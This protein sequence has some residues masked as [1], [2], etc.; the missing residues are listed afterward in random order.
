MTI[1]DVDTNLEAYRLVYDPTRLL[2][3]LYSKYGDIE[4]DYYLLSANQIFYNLPSHLNITYKENKYLENNEEFL[5]RFYK[6]IETKDRIPKLADY[7]KNYHLFFCRPF[8][9]NNKFGKIIR[10]YED[11]KAEIF[12]KNNYADSEN[13]L[14]DKEKDTEDK[15]GSSTL[16]SLDNITDNKII[17]DRRTKK[18]IENIDKNE[19]SSITLTLDS[20][21]ANNYLNNT[22]CLVSKRSVGSFEKNIYALVN[23]HIKK[24]I[25]NKRKCQK[26]PKN[27]TTRE[28]REKYSSPLC[29]FSYLSKNSNFNTKKN[30]SKNQY[31]KQIKNKNSL[32]SLVLNKNRINK[33]HNKAI[34]I[35]KGKNFFSPKCPFNK[36]NIVT[37]FEEFNKNRPLSGNMGSH[38]KNKTTNNNITTNNNTNTIKNGNT[39]NYKNFSKLSESLDK[40]KNINNINSTT[41]S[42]I[43]PVTNNRNTK[44]TSKIARTKKNSNNFNNK[45]YNSSNLNYNNDNN[46][47]QNKKFYIT[48][49]TS[50][51]N[52]KQGKHSITNKNSNKNYKNHIH[53]IKNRTVDFNSLNQNMLKFNSNNNFE[54]KTSNQHSQSK[55]SKKNLGSK[56]TLVKGIAM[57]KEVITN[58]SMSS[59]I[60]KFQKNSISK[61]IN[62]QNGNN[63]LTTKEKKSKNNFTNLCSINNSNHYSTKIE[64]KSPDINSKPKKNRIVFSERKNKNYSKIK[65]NKRKQNKPRV[66]QTQPSAYSTDFNINFEKGNNTSNYNRDDPSIISPSSY[67]SEN[68]FHTNSKGNIFQLKQD[69]T[70]YRS[71]QNF[72]KM[73][74]DLIE[75]DKNS[76]QKKSNNKRSEK[77]NKINHNSSITKKSQ[78]F[79]DVVNMK[80]NYQV[81]RNRKRGNVSNINTQ[82][83]ELKFI[84]RNC[85]VTNTNNKD[86]TDIDGINTLKKNN[87]FYRS[88]N[89]NVDNTND[90]KIIHVAESLYKVNKFSHKKKRKPKIFLREK[91]K[92]VVKSKKKQKLSDGILNNGSIYNKKKYIAKKENSSKRNCKVIRKENFSSKSNNTITQRER[93]S[94][95]QMINVNRNLNLLGKFENKNKNEKQKNN[96]V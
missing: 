15:K 20:L 34:L 4:E 26:N 35:K 45:L 49:T 37:K 25:I 29:H 68:F 54:N 86:I 67:Y 42:N 33:A 50:I 64:Y 76:A 1:E 31:Y 73:K 92:C 2:S 30:N 74:I 61:S 10:D 89:N 79:Y 21:N 94:S 65:D 32:Y 40:N 53:H 24:K 81:S 82:S 3:L 62:Y 38:K 52:N 43:T 6:I 63:N 51:K 57:I 72:N 22:Q 23:Y 39:S 84:K 41:N 46:F 75:V 77:K 27:Q 88:Y 9:R 58:P 17:F 95:F 36:K 83:Q 11:N 85:Y 60:K 59:D 69:N 13:E 48:K 44:N 87:K 7:Y 70:I 71:N 91:A 14:E 12:Y 78:E 96:H 8:F 47:K 66:K 18:I 80:D 28:K 5:K 55:N 56:F 19:M 90:L 16:S 93:G